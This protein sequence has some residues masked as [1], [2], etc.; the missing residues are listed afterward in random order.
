M[1]VEKPKTPK[2]ID[3]FNRYEGKSN[4][5][6]V[7]AITLA[8]ALV[9]STLLYFFSKSLIVYHV[10]YE[11]YGGTV[12]G[13]ELKPTEYRFLQR[14]HRPEN[15]RKKGFY[16]EKYCTDKKL[17]NEYTFGKML[18]SSKKLYVDWQP[19]VAFILN[20]AVGEENSDLS[21]KN[22]KLYYE[23][24]VKAGSEYSFPLIFNTNKESSHYGEQLFF[25]DN[26]ECTGDPMWDE[27]Y[28]IT[29]DTDVYGKWFDNNAYFELYG[30]QKA[31]KFILDDNGTLLSYSG[32]CNNIVIPNN[33]LAIKDCIH[34]ESGY[35][36]SP[37]KLVD[38][39]YSVW[40]NVKATL[41]RV[42]VNNGMLRLGNY[43]FATCKSLIKVAFLGD[44]VTYI[45]TKSF[46]FCD[47]LKEFKFPSSVSV[48]KAQTFEEAGKNVVGGMVIKNT[49]HLTILEDDAFINCYVKNLEFKSLEKMGERC[50]AGTQLESLTLSSPSVVVADVTNEEAGLNGNNIFQM[51]ALSSKFK[52]YV[53]SELLES[54]KVAV[55]WRQYSQYFTSITQ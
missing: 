38:N 27:S 10:S 52:I 31:D 21:L 23:E 16:I 19:G 6:R 55:G 7:I 26:P 49:D 53:P 42:Y 4:K 3:V 34:I 32:K 47:N 45:G 51:T 30:D 9:V 41:E 20:F 39:N 35:D 36:P 48:V 40:H 43:S 17:N 46:Q 33:V 5:L 37:E 14:T 54:Y 44:T 13:E 29:E 28:V 1:P 25:F 11:T 24:Y 22:L 2:E 50:L 15:L 18:W 12:F 8:I